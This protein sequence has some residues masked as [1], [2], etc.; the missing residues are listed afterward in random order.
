MPV[1][2]FHDEPSVGL[3][4]NELSKRSRSLLVIF[5]VLLVPCLF[6]VWDGEVATEEIV[7]VVIQKPPIVNAPLSPII[8]ENIGPNTESPTK[9]PVEN[10][11][12]SSSSASESPH[13]A[14]PLDNVASKSPTA[15]PL[16]PNDDDNNL[17]SSVCQLSASKRKQK[18][19]G[20]LLDPKDILRL[21][22]NSREDTIGSLREM[23]GEYFDPIFVNETKGEDEPNRYYGM[24]GMNPD[25]HQSRDRLKRKLKLKVLKMMTSIIT[26]ERSM[27]GCDC[28]QN[29]GIP[30]S[31][32]DEN[33]LVDLPNFYEK[34]VFANGGHSQAAG[35]GNKY[36]ESYTAVFAR[37]VRRVWEAIGIEFIDRNYA[38]GAML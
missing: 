20:D 2:E 22:N 15:T 5:V 10:E 18:F 23:Y 7:E 31:G 27:H 21:A 13:T 30:T 35:H 29:S 28:M 33:R 25:G 26:T 32:V 12:S 6:Y 11:H 17:C 16:I 1:D 14:P 19:G 9:S 37:D 3:S 34:Y 38:M 36:S 4:R 24:K 8:E